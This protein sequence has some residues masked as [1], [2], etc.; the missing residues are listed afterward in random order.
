MPK[1]VYSIAAITTLSNLCTSRGGSPEESRQMLAGFIAATISIAI[2]LDRERDEVIGWVNEGW[3]QV[4][5]SR[6]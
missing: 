2:A 3:D 6:S 1:N 5:R 4:E